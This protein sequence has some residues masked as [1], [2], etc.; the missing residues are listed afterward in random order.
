MDFKIGD[1][2]NVKQK[3]SEET[4]ISFDGTVVAVDTENETLDVIHYVGINRTDTAQVN[5]SEVR[6][7][8][9]AYGIDPIH[10]PQKTFDTLIA[11]YTK[12]PETY[13]FQLIGLSRHYMKILDA[14]IQKEGKPSETTQE[15]L[16][17]IDAL[18]NTAKAAQS[19]K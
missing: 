6:E 2:V 14:E 12:A 18:L 5:F 10:F 7:D 11:F 17:Q 15:R 13:L 3:V 4:S 1:A 16:N 8:H 19:R 9:V